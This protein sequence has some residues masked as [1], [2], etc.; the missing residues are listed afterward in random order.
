M[1]RIRVLTSGT[2]FLFSLYCL[3]FNHT[4]PFSLSI[5]IYMIA[6]IYFA[7]FPIKDMLSFANLSLYKGR[8][9]EKNYIP[10]PE[11]QQ[12]EFIKMKRRYDYRAISVYGCT[13]QFIS[14]RI[15]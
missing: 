4:L 9:F 10:N 12:Q 8:Q 7:F 14:V 6:F 1:N 3:F 11:L 13:R 5:E 2:L 15:Y